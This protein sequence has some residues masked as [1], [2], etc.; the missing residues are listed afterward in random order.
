MANAVEERD[1]KVISLQDDNNSRKGTRV[2]QERENTL[3]CE[4]EKDMVALLSKFEY[5][6]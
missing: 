6:V 2:P 3:S 4:R 5:K 1:E